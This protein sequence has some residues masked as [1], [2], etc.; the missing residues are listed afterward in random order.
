MHKPENRAEKR[1]VAKES[2]KTQEQRGGTAVHPRQHG[3]ATSTAGCGK[4][5]RELM[6]AYGGCGSDASRTLRF[7]L[8]FGSW[9]FTLD[10]PTW[11]YWACLANSLD[12]A[13]LKV[14]TFL[15]ILGSTRVN[16]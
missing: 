10:Y 4:H 2:E 12:L 5:H 15:P 9:V 11:A 7:V 16:L 14:H 8:L 3:H 6:V 1:T 13:W